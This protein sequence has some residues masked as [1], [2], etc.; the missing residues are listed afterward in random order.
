MDG[1][2]EIDEKDEEAAKV[3][4]LIFWSVVGFL[5]LMCLA[6]VG[7]VFSSFCLSGVRCVLGFVCLVFSLSRV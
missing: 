4:I 2:E 3:T 6:Y 5:G 7:F 1:E